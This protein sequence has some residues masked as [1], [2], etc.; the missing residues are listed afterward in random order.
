MPQSVII[1]T[2]SASPVSSRKAAPANEK[3]EGGGFSD[4]FNKQ[5][6]QDEA[7][8]S[9]S[10]ATQSKTAEAGKEVAADGKNLP[11]EKAQSSSSA[12]GDKKASE[13]PDDQTPAT[14]S[15]DDSKQSDKQKEA[16]AESKT[17][18]PSIVTS[19]ST[20]AAKQQTDYRHWQAACESGYCNRR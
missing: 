3:A 13:Q 16:T 1:Q 6:R 20:V 2:E 17:A 4:H 7:G 19:P 5:V 11:T 10:M 9:Q 12:D 15:H 18:E 14:E 8:E